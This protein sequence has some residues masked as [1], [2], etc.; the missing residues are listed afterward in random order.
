MRPVIAALLFSGWFGCTSALDVPCCPR[1][2]DGK[3]VVLAPAPVGSSNRRLIQFGSPECEEQIC[4]TDLEA[5]DGGPPQGYCSRPCSATNACPTSSL[6]P[7]RC[8]SSVPASDGG[9]V[10]VCL[11]PALGS[12]P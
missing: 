5:V 10:S 8:D 2:T 12:T 11:R 4:V 7:M 6:G 3:C 1:G 9:A